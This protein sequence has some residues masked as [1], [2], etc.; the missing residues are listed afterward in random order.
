MTWQA[1]GARPYRLAGLGHFLV[2]PSGAG[3]NTD[4]RHGDEALGEVALAGED[5]VGAVR[6]GLKLVHISA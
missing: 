2:G 5:G 6:Q 3:A 1:I 4:A